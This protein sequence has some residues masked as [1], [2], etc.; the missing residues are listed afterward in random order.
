MN[1]IKG[2]I[3]KT[4]FYNQESG[5]VVALF[6][7][8]ETNVKKLEVNKTITVTGTVLD[9]NLDIPMT[10]YGDYV[11]NDKWGMQF[12]I[13]KVEVE[14]PTS[15]EAIEDFLA[16]SFIAGCGEVT[17]KKI[18]EE[19]GDKALEIIKENKNNLLKIEGMTEVRAT[20]IYASLVNFNK[21][22][23]VIL[24]LQKLGF[25]IEECSKIYNHF[26]E[27]IDDVLENNFY[28]LKEVVDFKKVDS[29]FRKL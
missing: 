17:A 16:S 12:V 8:K 5:F 9:L 24:K 13:D 29:I 1:Y 10:I 6:R 18:V 19:F 11:K 15:K 14:M 21:S 3:K 4:I 26:K 25:S 28:D 7:V 22:E 23:E 20:K 27:R 2:K